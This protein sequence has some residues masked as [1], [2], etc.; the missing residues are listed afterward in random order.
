MLCVFRTLRAAAGESAPSGARDALFFLPVPVSVPLFRPLSH[1]LARACTNA[2]T[3]PLLLALR[4]SGSSPHRTSL[5]LAHTPLPLSLSFIFSFLAAS[6]QEHVARRLASCIASRRVASFSVTCTFAPRRCQA[7]RLRFAGVN[8][9]AFDALPPR[10]RTF[11]RNDDAVLSRCTL[12]IHV[13]HRILFGRIK[14]LATKRR[15]SAYRF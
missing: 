6:D 4:L 7:T 3:Y 2:R 15:R 5:F 14:V 11:S 12:P 9:P 13:S 10:W 8:V 1:T